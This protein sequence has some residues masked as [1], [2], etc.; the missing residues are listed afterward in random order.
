MRP[1]LRS[2]VALSFAGSGGLAHAQVY[3]GQDADGAVVLSNFQSE[4]A[5]ALIVSAPVV[6]IDRAAPI[7]KPELQQ[8]GTARILRIPELPDRLRPLIHEAAAEHN[9]PPNLIQAVIAVESGYNPNAVSRTGAKGLMQLMPQTA[10]R[11]GVANVYDQRANVRGGAQYL[12]WLL[13]AFEGNLELA[14]AGYNAGENAVI[15]SGYKIPPY[16]ETQDYVPKVLAV[17]KQLTAQAAR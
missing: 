7:E 1:I 8:Q 5:S 17:Y 13:G 16:R 3:G 11:F 6:Q 4:V 2:L 15:R 10:S 14:L 9:L 12:A